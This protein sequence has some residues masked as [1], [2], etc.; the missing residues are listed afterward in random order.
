MGVQSGP[1]AAPNRYGHRFEGWSDSF[2]YGLCSGCGCRENTD[3]AV[4]PCPEPAHD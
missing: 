2:G 1:P 3:A 4:E